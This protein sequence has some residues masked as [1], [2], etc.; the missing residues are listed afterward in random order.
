M[1]EGRNKLQRIP[2]KLGQLL[3]LWQMRMNFKS[4]LLALYFFSFFSHLM[5][6]SFSPQFFYVFF[7]QFPVFFPLMLI[8]KHSTNIDGEEQ[9]NTWQRNTNT[10]GMHWDLFVANCKKGTKC[11][12]PLSPETEHHITDKGLKARLKSSYN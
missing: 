8:K 12:H 1:K 10:I 2:A 9:I 6:F 4:R 5:F 7:A 11:E 3:G